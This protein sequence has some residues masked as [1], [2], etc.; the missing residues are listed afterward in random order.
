MAV[1]GEEEKCDGGGAP[2]PD[3]VSRKKR[4]T[5][6]ELPDLSEQRTGDGGRELH[7]G[8]AMAAVAAAKPEPEKEMGKQKKAEPPVV[9]FN[10]GDWNS[11]TGGVESFVHGVV[12]FVF[13]ATLLFRLVFLV[14]I[15]A[16]EADGGVGGGE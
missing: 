3:P 2:G 13:L 12:L 5:T 8:E 16:E 7:G 1:D 14:I 4:R 6:T 9:L 11:D 10:F 15:A